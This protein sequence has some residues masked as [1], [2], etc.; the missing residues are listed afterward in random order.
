VNLGLYRIISYISG[1]KVRL[2]KS[3]GTVEL[4]DLTVNPLL[5]EA[6]LSWTIDARFIYD[7]RLLRV[8]YETLIDFET[9]AN[10]VD[11]G[12]DRVVAASTLARAPHPVYVGFQLRYQLKPT[13]ASDIDT[14]EA[15]RFLAAFIREFPAFDILNV[16]DIV[17]AFREEYEDEV[18]NVK[19]PM[20]VDYF[21]ISPDGGKVEFQSTDEISIKESLAKTETDAERYLTATAHGVSDNTIKYL[22]FEDLI[23][24]ILV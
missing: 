22:S 20:T 21:L 9:I 24:V 12:D 7:D 13:A 1:T 5:A 17:T 11:A 18:G 6:N 23:E 14:D 8:S 3:S 2:V 10:Y 4:D 16:S 15:T 19:N